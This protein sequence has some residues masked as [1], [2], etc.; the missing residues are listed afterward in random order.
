MKVS[1]GQIMQFKK[2]KCVKLPE[3]P[4]RIDN[5]NDISNDK[6]FGLFAYDINDKIAHYI[7]VEKLKNGSKEEK[8]LFKKFKRFS[9]LLSIDN[10]SHLLSPKNVIDIDEINEYLLLH[11]G[12]RFF[13]IWDNDNFKHFESYLSD[14]FQ[15]KQLQSYVQ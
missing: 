4:Y 8:Q 9:S 1:I 10:L 2:I 13:S 3:G 11:R 12:K 14:R 7:D 15:R 5:Y 6:E